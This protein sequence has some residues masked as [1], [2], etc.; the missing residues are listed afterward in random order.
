MKRKSKGSEIRMGFLL[1]V[2]AHDGTCPETHG[3]S[4]LLGK[5]DWKNFPKINTIF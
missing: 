1:Q 3:E 2:K 5:W 4:D